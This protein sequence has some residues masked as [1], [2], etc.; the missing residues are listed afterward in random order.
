MDSIYMYNSRVVVDISDVLS[1]EQLFLLTLSCFQTM[2]TVFPDRRNAFFVFQQSVLCLIGA[3]GALNV[4]KIH[5]LVCS[6]VT[7]SQ[8]LMHRCV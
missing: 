6:A 4:H 7:M 8:F 1:V 3:G 2:L 5:F